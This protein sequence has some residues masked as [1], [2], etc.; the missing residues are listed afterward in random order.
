[1]SL[2]RL[3]LLASVLI[4]VPLL[5]ACSNQSIQ[6]RSVY[7]SNLCNIDQ[8]V[9]KAVNSQQ[10]LES[11]IVPTLKNFSDKPEQLPQLDFSIESV[12]LV[13][14]G[15]QSTSGY[16][17]VLNGDQALLKNDRLLLPV[18]ITKPAPGNAQAQVITRPCRILSLPRVEFSEIVLQSGGDER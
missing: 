4:S 3:S 7:S 2:T 10:E 8:A 5:F 12:I 16:A 14:V 9:I 13:A 1:M 6:L 18:S 15:E 11:I 17:V